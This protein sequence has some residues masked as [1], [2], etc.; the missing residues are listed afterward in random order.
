MKKLP[1]AA[2]SERGWV[3][4]PV[5]LNSRSVVSL[6]EILPNEDIRDV[7][8]VR[9]ASV[10]RGEDTVAALCFSVSSCGCLIGPEEAKD[11]AA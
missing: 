4:S 8:R 2:A 9:F 6:N 5:P 10:V 7:S 3:S 1:F 11:T